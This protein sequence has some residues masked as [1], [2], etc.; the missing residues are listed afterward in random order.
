MTGVTGVVRTAVVAISVMAA[1]A[2]ATIS[3]TAGAVHAASAST[4][5]AEPQDDTPYAASKIIWRWR[6]V[7]N[8]ALDDSRAF[9]SEEVIDALEVFVSPAAVRVVREKASE[10]QL[11]K[12]DAV[13]QRFVLEMVKVSTRQPDGSL[14]VEE[15]AIEP[16]RKAICPV[17][18]FCDDPPDRTPRGDVS[19]GI[20]GGGPMPSA[21]CC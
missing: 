3:V 11:K 8:L 2:T 21:T 4:G 18:P 20:V 19:G 13:L 12:A 1:G 9:A 14:I 15:S 6:T 16:A 5:L 7:M 10:D 17:Y